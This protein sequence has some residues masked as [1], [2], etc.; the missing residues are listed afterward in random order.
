MENTEIATLY[1]SPQYRSVAINGPIPLHKSANSLCQHLRIPFDKTLSSNKPSLEDL[2]S[3]FLTKGQPIEDST[4][5][6]DVTGENHELDDAITTRES[7]AGNGRSRKMIESVP[8]TILSA[9][10]IIYNVILNNTY[11]TRCRK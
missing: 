6:C 7:A 9:M 3:H 1:N 10:L 8:Q 11:P 2:D 5:L 4:L